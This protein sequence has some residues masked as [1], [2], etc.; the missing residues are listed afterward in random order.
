MF[1]DGGH[2]VVHKRL[3]FLSILFLC[4]AGIV[5][6][7]IVSASGI[8]L[9]SLHVLD[10]KSDTVVELVQSAVEGLPELRASLPPVL[11][12]AIDD[13]RRPDYLSS[14]NVSVRLL[15]GDKDSQYRRAVVEVE[16]EGDEVVS[17][18]TLRVVGLDENGD[19]VWERNTC[20][21]TPL[22]IEDEWRGPL[23]PHET[24]RF[25]LYRYS[26]CRTRRPVVECRELVHEITEIRVWRGKTDSDNITDENTDETVLAEV[27]ADR[28]SL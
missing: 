12:D 13:E 15:E 16:N 17:L 14:L 27:D 4:L 9:Y 5:M 11:A 8:V 28:N 24:R 20:V 26:G 2:T 21:A 1:N 6:T 18:L 22:Q 25:P 23:M 19:P 10:G 7:A 3:S